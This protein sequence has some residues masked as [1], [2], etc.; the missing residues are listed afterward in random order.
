MPPAWPT[1]KADRGETP[2]H[3]RSR[4]LIVAFLRIEGTLVPDLNRAQA[5]WG[6]DIGCRSGRLLVLF[7][8]VSL[9]HPSWWHRWVR[10]R[11]F[12]GSG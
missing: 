6:A 10:T 11:T 3:K 5:D 2:R 7:N 1:A 8:M 4:V 12:R 9:C